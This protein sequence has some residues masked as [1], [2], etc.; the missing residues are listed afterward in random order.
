MNE[1][2]NKKMNTI[3]NI[4]I[5]LSIFFIFC[6]IYSSVIP[7]DLS[8]YK[9]EIKNLNTQVSTLTEQ[10]KN[11]ENQITTLSE[12]NKTLE[13][14]N[15]K[16]KDEKNDLNN[17]MEE[18]SKASSVSSTTPSTTS[19]NNSS[20][21]SSTSAPKSVSTTTPSNDNSQIVWV[22]ETGSKYHVQ[23]CSTLRGKGHQITLQQA[24]AEGKQACKRCKP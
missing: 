7:N 15:Q 3:L 18:L 2:K 6:I 14:E 22:G 19:D 9:K 13:S 21:Q 20:S 11:N 4:V 16:L 10:I 8:E 12:S 5:A 24:L 23:S 1:S 17:Q